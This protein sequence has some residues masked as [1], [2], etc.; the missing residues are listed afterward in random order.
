MENQQ[1]PTPDKTKHSLVGDVG[2]AAMFSGAGILVGIALYASLTIYVLDVDQATITRLTSLFEIIRNVGLAIGGV[3]AA[4]LTWL[5]LAHNKKRADAAQATAQTN[6]S[7][8]EELQ[9]TNE[10]NRTLERER[11]NEGALLRCVQWL[12]SDPPA[13]TKVAIATARR[14]LMHTEAGYELA[15][16][17][18]MAVAREA[19][20]SPIDPFAPPDDPPDDHETIIELR[21]NAADDWRHELVRLIIEADLKY[22]SS[23]EIG[24]I[25]LSWFTL[26]LSKIEGSIRFDQTDLMGAFLFNRYMERNHVTVSLEHCDIQAMIFDDI[27]FSRLRLRG[28]YISEAEFRGCDLRFLAIEGRPSGGAKFHYCDLS[29]VDLRPLIRGRNSFTGSSMTGAIMTTQQMKTWLLSDEQR[30]A[31]RV[32]DETAEPTTSTPST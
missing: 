23:S 24:R 27:A 16:E 19:L 31:A 15:R 25:D 17:A 2:A 22:R 8:L 12:T 11:Y 29:N 5:A 26:D 3:I 28:G 1:T 21:A 13:Q 7:Q 20:P 9:R 6:M 30:S 18:L 14:L 32:Q 10:H 4:I